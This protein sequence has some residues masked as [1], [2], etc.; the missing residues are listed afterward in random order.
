MKI[1]F[2]IVFKMIWKLIAPLFH[3]S[4]SFVLFFLNTRG[5][6]CN[7]YKKNKKTVIGSI[8]TQS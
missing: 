8:G 3:G 4:L 2:R 7:G 5:G 1:N 6:L